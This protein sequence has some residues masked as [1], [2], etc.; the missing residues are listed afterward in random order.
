LTGLAQRD[1]A[2]QAI[3]VSA[4][5]NIIATQKTI[6]PAEQEALDYMRKRFAGTLP[7][8]S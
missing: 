6:H 8:E 7:G 2:T 1:P 4:A 5:E 3:L